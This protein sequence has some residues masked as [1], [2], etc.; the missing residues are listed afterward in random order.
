M[1]L[2]KVERYVDQER[3]VPHS[4]GFILP[5]T[6]AVSVGV[7]SFDVYEGLRLDVAIHH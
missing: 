6:I 7:V 1:V 2:G 3:E 4:I 5:V